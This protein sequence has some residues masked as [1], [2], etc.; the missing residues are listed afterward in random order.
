M[1]E[2]LYVC[3]TVHVTVWGWMCVCGCVYVA[4]GNTT[5]AGR[6]FALVAGMKTTTSASYLRSGGPGTSI[7]RRKLEQDAATMQ[8]AH[9]PMAQ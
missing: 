4:E 9:V 8:Q 5:S 2:M 7:H 6:V 1:N 3:K